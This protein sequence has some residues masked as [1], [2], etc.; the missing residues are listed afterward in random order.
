MENIGMKGWFDVTK[1][2]PDGTQEKFFVPNIVVADGKTSVASMIGSD[3]ASAVAFDHLAIGSGEQAAVLLNSGLIHEFYG[4]V[5]G[6]GAVIGSHATFTGS[7]GISGTV[8]ISEYA[9]FNAVTA[10]SMLARASGTGVAAISGD[11]LELTY[12]VVVG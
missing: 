7:F 12:T 8:S 2:S 1:T 4:R 6:S 10:G 3:T 5:D 9:V 11:Y